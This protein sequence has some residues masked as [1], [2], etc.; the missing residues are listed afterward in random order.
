MLLTSFAFLICA[1]ASALAQQVSYDTAHNVTPITGTWSSGAM[2]VVTGPQYVFANNLTFTYPPTTGVS[3]TLYK[4]KLP[5][6][7]PQ[8]GPRVSEFR[9]KWLLVLIPCGDGYQRVEDPCAARSDFTEVYNDTELYQSWQIFLDPVDGPKLHMFAFDGSP[10]S[11]MRLLS[12]QPEMLPNQRLHSTQ[13]TTVL[14]RS[15]TNV[16]SPIRWWNVAALT[17]I[18]AMLG[19]WRAAALAGAET[20]RRPIMDTEQTLAKS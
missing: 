3:F 18:G 10:I 4:S 15:T 16:A 11:P 5:H 9:A 19:S 6:H 13:T 17:T 1:S 14:R 2:N 12:A 8:L 7:G 20:E